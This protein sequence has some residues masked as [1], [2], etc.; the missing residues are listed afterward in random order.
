MAEIPLACYDEAPN[1]IIPP[2][3]LFAV[4]Y[5]GY[6]KNI[7]KVLQTLGGQRG[8]K[9]AVNEDLMELRFRPGDPFCHPINGDVIPTSNLLLKVTWK[10]KKRKSRFSQHISD[11]QTG[12]EGMADYQ[13]V[14]NPND[15]IPKY[16]RTLENFDVDNIMD[17]DSIMSGENPEDNLPPPS[18]SRIECPMEYGYRQNMA[19]VKV[20]IQKGDG[21]VRYNVSS[22]SPAFN[23]SPVPDAPPPDSV[24]HRHLASPES[25][26]RIQ[27]AT[28]DLPDLSV[29]LGETDMDKAG[30]IGLLPLVSYWMLNGPWRDC[31]IRYGYDPRRNKEARFYQLLDIRNTRRPTR[32]DRAKRLLRVQGESTTDLCGLPHMSDDATNSIPRKTH[33]FDGHTTKRD[34]A[35]FQM[36]DITDPL[37]KNL[38]ESPDAVQEDCTERDGHYKQDALLKM[39]KIMRRKFK[40]LIEGK[41]LKDE[42]FED[43]LREDHLGNDDD[44][45]CEEPSDT[46]GEFEEDPLEDRV[47]DLMRN[48]Q[49]SQQQSVEH[50]DELVQDDEGILYEPEDLNDYED[51]FGDNDSDYN[52]DELDDIQ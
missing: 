36:C 22:L 52:D 41:T 32:L 30:A 10:R 6:V 45:E 17:F 8:L 12:N 5:P 46:E 9:K 47:S 11:D 34:I 24:R 23:F 15:T 18:F 1:R 39:R 51:I 29:V 35:V 3:Q 48:L 26:S 50:E 42:D 44:H 28:T 38:I 40:A 37:L 21:Q 43:L 4:E 16:R 2:N 27:K 25:V 19:V 49:R 14:P 7:D 20:L 13:F 33:I 31:W